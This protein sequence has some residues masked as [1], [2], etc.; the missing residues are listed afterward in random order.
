MRRLL[1]LL[2]V[3]LLCSCASA[4]GRGSTAAAELSKGVQEGG[5]KVAAASVRGAEAV[6]DSVGTAY[7]G[8][9]KGFDQPASSDYGRY[10]EDYVDVVRK[11]LV[12][13]EGVTEP[14]SFR[15]GKPVRAYLNKGLLRGGEVDWQGWVVDV[16]IETKT[17][18]GQPRVDEYVVRMTDGDV[19]EVVEK[20][21]AGSI[22]RLAAEPT[23]ASRQR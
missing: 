23:P 21:Y 15:F 18:F 8:V 2:A 4:R 5:G 1:L 7:H 20:A 17:A 6:S 3:S 14:A 10:P 16:A 19:V 22:R 12:R 13:F 9:K 11:H